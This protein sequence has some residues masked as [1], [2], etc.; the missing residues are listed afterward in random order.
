MLYVDDNSISSVEILYID[1]PPQFTWKVIIMKHA[2]CL[3]YNCRH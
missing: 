3:S 1:N 2:L